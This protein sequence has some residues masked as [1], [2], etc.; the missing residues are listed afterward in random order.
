MS[1]VP[2]HGVRSPQLGA[3]GTRYRGASSTP[4][5]IVTN[6]LGLEARLH[7]AL[8]AA[9]GAPV[10]HL[11]GHP[12]HVAVPAGRYRQCSTANP[13]LSLDPIRHARGHIGSWY[14]HF[15][16][17]VDVDNDG[18]SGG[19]RRSKLLWM[20]AG[21]QHPRR[22]TARRAREHVNGRGSA[23]LLRGSLRLR[24]RRGDRSGTKLPGRGVA[25]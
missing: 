9:K 22:G 10:P 25:G 3:L 14:D 2:V 21:E 4:D 24:A 6:G 11:I 19:R 16:I 1:R 23:R 12:V 20:E 7:G 5:L 18:N 17:D 13:R 15:H 8:E